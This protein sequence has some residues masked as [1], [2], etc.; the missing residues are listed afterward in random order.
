[1]PSTV[2][3]EIDRV[4][5]TLPA[6]V[7]DECSEQH[8]VHAPSNGQGLTLCVVHDGFRSDLPIHHSA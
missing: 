7:G 5:H 4:Q 2:E 3:Q 6:C 8:T 1:M